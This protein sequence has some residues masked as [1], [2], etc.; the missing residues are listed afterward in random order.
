MTKIFFYVATFWVVLWTL[1]TIITNFVCKEFGHHRSIGLLE[2]LAIIV[3]WVFLGVFVWDPFTNETLCKATGIV[4]HFTLIFIMACLVFEAFFA[5]SIVKGN[6]EKN[7]S[8]PAFLNYIL[9]FICAGIPA[10]ISYIELK[11]Y[12]ASTGVHCFV[13]VFT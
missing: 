5:R 6:S 7:G 12:Y 13:V 1:I 8:L 3:L 11:E 2:E 9:P 4:L 10:A